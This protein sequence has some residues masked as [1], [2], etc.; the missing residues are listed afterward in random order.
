MSV[1]ANSPSMS[2]AQVLPVVRQPILDRQQ[3]LFAYELA[4]PRG[5]NT[6]GS[7]ALTGQTL[8]AIADGSLKQLVRDN[9]AFLHVSRELLVSHAETLRQNTRLGVCVGPALAGDRRPRVPSRSQRRT[10]RS[11]PP[12][13][14]LQPHPLAG[15]TRRN[16]PAGSLDSGAPQNPASADANRLPPP[17]R[18]WSRRTCDGCTRQSGRRLHARLA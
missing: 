13:R 2:Q 9:R 4:F 1:F 7:E 5:S 14:G 6:D 3:A 8:A 12:G 18:H 10:F 17:R 16:E 15:D 11:P